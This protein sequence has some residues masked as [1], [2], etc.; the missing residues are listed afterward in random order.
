MKN[1]SENSRNTQL[2][3]FSLN[4]NNVNVAHVFLPAKETGEK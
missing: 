1:K 3:L 2:F 4:K